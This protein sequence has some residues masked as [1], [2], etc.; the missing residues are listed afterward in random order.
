MDR[1]NFERQKELVI[2]IIPD[3]ESKTITII[4]SGVG[5]TKTDLINNLGTMTRPGTKQLKQALKG[6]ANE[7]LV[8]H[9]L[10]GLGFY[11][12]YL[13]ADRVIVTSKHDDDEQYAWE[14]S[15]GGSFT[16]RPDHGASLGRGTKVMLHLTKD[17]SFCHYMKETTIKGVV[18]NHLQLV[19]Y[20]IMLLAEKFRQQIFILLNCGYRWRVAL[21]KQ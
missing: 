8:N 11:S 21:A 2:R 14:S 1:S 16:I 13:V 10:F 3:A 9:L 4:D 6:G 20:P 19:G 17:L 7:Y 18:N 5:M 15:G 12:V